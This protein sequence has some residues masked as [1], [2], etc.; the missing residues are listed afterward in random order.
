MHTDKATVAVDAAATATDADVTAVE[1]QEA[2]TAIPAA[3][4][5][6]KAEPHSIYGDLVHDLGYKK[7]TLLTIM[8][9]LTNDCYFNNLSSAL[10]CAHHTNR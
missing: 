9:D 1:L 5:A 7:V 2:A 8:Y 10:V 4:V 3:A 6:T